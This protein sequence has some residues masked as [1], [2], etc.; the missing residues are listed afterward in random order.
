MTFQPGMT[1]RKGI[2]R[3]K[4][5]YSLKQGRPPLLGNQNTSLSSKVTR[6]LIR[7][8]HALRKAYA[9]AV[10]MKDSSRADSLQ[11]EIAIS[12]G[13]RS[14]QLAS[15]LGQSAERGG[16]SSRVLVQWLEP[17]FE[18]AKA[19]KKRLHMLEIG[20]LSTKNACSRVDCLDVTR[21]DLHS[22]EPQI[23]EVDFMELPIPDDNT[24]KFDTISLSLVLNY[25]PDA[26][27]RGDMLRRISSF[28]RLPPDGQRSTELLPCLFLVLP[29][30]C[31]INSRYLTE[32]R[33]KDVMASLGF[34]QARVKTTSKLYYALWTYDKPASSRGSTFKK[35]ELQSGRSK[36]NFGIALR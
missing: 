26:A 23:Q 32:T 15:I 30:P 14:Y 16:D 33:L 34:A 7:R 13:L 8:H 24:M 12:G 21:I 5:R 1:I 31:V 17:A 3:G 28:L 10:E 2:H 36:N 29:L 20:A 35:E 19:R 4:K 11:A 22:Q 18:H 9:E 6:S 25:V 27:A